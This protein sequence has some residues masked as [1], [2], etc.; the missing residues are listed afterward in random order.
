MKCW[1][2]LAQLDLVLPM[3]ALCFL[4]ENNMLSV[5]IKEFLPSDHGLTSADDPLL[6]DVARLGAPLV[7][8]MHV[9]ISA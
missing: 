4:L 5:A 6:M 7:L 1:I 2:G 8:R 3:A 9:K